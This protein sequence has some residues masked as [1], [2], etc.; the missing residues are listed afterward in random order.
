MKKITLLDI[1]ELSQL[2]YKKRELK[3]LKWFYDRGVENFIILPILGNDRAVF[4]EYD[5]IVYVGIAGSDDKQ[6]WR[7]NG[8][9]FRWIKRLFY[10][11]KGYALPAE[12]IKSLFESW[13]YHMHMKPCWFTLFGHSRG[14]SIEQNL[15]VQMDEDPRYKD[16]FNGWGFGGPGG[17]PRKFAK[18]RKNA[19]NVKF[20]IKGDPVHVINFLARDIGE[21]VKLPKQIKGFFNR[22]KHLFKGEMNHRSYDCIKKYSPWNNMDAQGNLL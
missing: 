9:V 10:G 19:R 4:F 8:Q 3:L 7:E 20:E 14:E 17:G 11:F 18:G 21:V 16:N 15:Y 12:N 1:E 13:I 6:D 2:V 5:N 22:I